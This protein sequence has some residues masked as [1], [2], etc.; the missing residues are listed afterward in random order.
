VIG[1]DLLDLSLND[2]MI[3]KK[4][5]LSA[6]RI[7]GL[8]SLSTNTRSDE[9]LGKPFHAVLP[10]IELIFGQDEESDA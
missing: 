8:N 10:D 6:E 3:F 9:R 5:S 7:H 1:L 2:R 4:P